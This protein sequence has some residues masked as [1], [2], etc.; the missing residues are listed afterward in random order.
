MSF[1]LF[2]DCLNVVISERSDIVSSSFINFAIA[3]LVFKSMHLFIFNPFI[4]CFTSGNTMLAK[5][6]VGVYMTKWQI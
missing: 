1:A 4:Y 5:S 3:N 2:S 6:F